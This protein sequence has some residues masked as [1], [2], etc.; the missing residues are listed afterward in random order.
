MARAAKEIA[1]KILL[2]ARPR[3]EGFVDFNPSHLCVRPFGQTVNSAY[4]TTLSMGTESPPLAQGRPG[5]KGCQVFVHDMSSDTS[6]IF[7]TPPL[8]RSFAHS[9]EEAHKK[10]QAPRLDDSEDEQKARRRRSPQPK[11]LSHRAI[12]LLPPRP[13]STCATSVYQRRHLCLPEVPSKA[14]APLLEAGGVLLL[15]IGVGQH[16]PGY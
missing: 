6:F 3:T 11:G 15:Q 8:P 5:L 16:Q 14:V 7:H 2:R 12:S 9:K 4:P 10:M 1:W 13:S